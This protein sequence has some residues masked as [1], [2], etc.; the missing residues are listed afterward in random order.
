MKKILILGMLLVSQLGISQIA[1]TTSGQP[2]TNGAVIAKSQLGYPAAEALFRVRNNGATTTNVWI[3]CEDLVNNSGNN[4]QLCFGIECLP[5]VAEGIIYPTTGSVTLAPN[6]SNGNFDHFLNDNA[7]NGTY[8]VDFV[9]RFFQ[10]NQTTPGGPEV[11]NSITVT[12]RYDPNLTIDEV[13]QLEASGVI[14]KSTVIEN[15][16]VLDVL[17]STSMAV[18]DL[19]GKVVYNA[20]LA[21]GVQTIDFSTIASGLYVINFTNAQGNSST[22]KVIKK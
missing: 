1:L 16:L 20:E 2:L 7:G 6:A 8:P 17:K 18:Y 10:T 14:V 9:F 11:G 21:Y 22:K 15:E 4:F 19:N 13:N 12:Y 5:E 3:K